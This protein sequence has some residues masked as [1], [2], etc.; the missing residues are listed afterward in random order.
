MLLTIKKKD[1]KIWNKIVNFKN[2]IKMI[3]KIM[4]ISKL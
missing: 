1:L 3:E 2:V 4:L